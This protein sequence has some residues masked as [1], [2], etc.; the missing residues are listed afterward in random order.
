MR[1]F[2]VYN[3]HNNFSNICRQYKK[4]QSKQTVRSVIEDKKITRKNRF[5]PQP[6]QN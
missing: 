5:T 4:I 1:E 2:T 6:N 3:P